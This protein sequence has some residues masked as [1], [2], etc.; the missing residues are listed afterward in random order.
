[1]QIDLKSV[2][3]QFASSWISGNCLPHLHDFS[4]Y[5]LLVLIL[6]QDP[7]EDITPLIHLSQGLNAQDAETSLQLSIPAETKH[8][9]TLTPNHPGVTVWSEAPCVWITCCPPDPYSPDSPGLSRTFPTLPGSP[10]GPSSALRQS[11]TGWSPEVEK[12]TVEDWKLTRSRS[13]QRK[14]KQNHDLELSA[15]QLCFKVA[16]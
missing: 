7:A 9:N 14:T 11:L 16:D 2:K 4:R 10:C 13:W 5:V 12:R 8:R 1:M 3:M 15:S 6:L